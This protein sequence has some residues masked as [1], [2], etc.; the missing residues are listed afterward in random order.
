M[1]NIKREDEE[2]LDG[3][4]YK[5]VNGCKNPLEFIIKLKW[6]IVLAEHIIQLWRWDIDKLYDECL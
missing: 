6:I 4:C 5:N 2:K 3:D 1:R